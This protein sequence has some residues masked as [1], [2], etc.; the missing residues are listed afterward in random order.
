VTQSGAVGLPRG[1]RRVRLGDVVTLRNG[2]AFK[3]SEWSKSG[4]PI[5]RIQNLKYPDAPFNHFP[6]DLPEQFAAR[7]GDLLFAWSGTPGTSFGAHVWEGPDAWINQHI[8]RVDFSP[9]DFDRDFLKLALQANLASYIDQAQGGVG[10][11]H[12]T[13]SKLNDSLLV[14]PPLAKQR[15][16][17]ETVT[18]VLWKRASCRE[19]LQGSRR[20]VERFRR[21][22]LA[23]AYTGGLT[24]VWREENPDLP[25]VE[26]AVSELE[27][28]R[29]RRR[30]A[31]E[32]ELDLGL[33]ALP[34]S[35]VVSTVGAAAEILEY[36]TSRR[37]E[38]MNDGLDLRDLK[39]A[40]PDDELSRLMLKEGDLLFNR[41]NSPELVGKS[42]V[43]YGSEPMSFASYLIRVRFNP[44]VAEP[45]FV[46]YWINSAWGREWARL[47]KT[48]GVSQSNIN[49]TKLSLMPLPLPPLAEQRVIV[50]R[51]SALLTRAEDLLRRVGQAERRVAASFQ[52]ILAKAFRGE[53]SNGKGPHL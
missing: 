9:D 22:V 26:H 36:G 27:G 48:D 32:T 10:L 43:F 50:E 39:Y 42:A 15:Q 4:R 45:E 46:N 18:A 47:A 37:S 29:K 16:I 38:A 7:P 13:K 17:A 2:R 14:A 49:G 40:R 28:S 21:A 30:R 53:L 3:R 51:A 33:P 20:A 12:I 34:G 24:A 1:W 19:R 52:P 23:A 41:T 35:Y 11:A 8:F 31:V 6:G 44:D 5:I 25:S